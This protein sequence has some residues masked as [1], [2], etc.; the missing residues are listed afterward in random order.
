M[1]EAMRRGRC[2]AVLAGMG[3]LVP[4][5]GAQVAFRDA[6]RRAV[7]N[8]PRV[9]A[10][11][12]DVK[13][14][15][16]GV[17]AVRDM[18][19][20]SVVMGGGVGDAY[21]ITLTVPTIFTVSA[22][23]LVFSLQQRAYIRGA[24]SD[25]EAARLALE[26]VKQQVEE[27]AAI[28]YLS[29]DTAEET[30]AAL[31]EQYEYAEKLAAIMQDRLHAN[32]ESELAVLQYR[33]GELQITLARMDAADQVEDL[34]GHLAQ[35]TGI[36]A[37]G[38]KIAPETIPAISAASV[39]ETVGEGG[40]METPGIRAAAASD[41]AK[42]DRARGDAEYT[43]RPQVSFAATYGRV[44][45][46]ENVSQYYNLNGIYNTASF[47]FTVQFPLLDRVRKA[48]ADESRLDAKLA[49]MDLEVLRSDERAGRHKLSR[50]LPELTTKAELADLNYEIAQKQVESAEAEAQHAT[51]EPPVT[52][53]ET[54]NAHIEERQ[55]YMEVLSAKLEARKA[56]ITYLRM[57]NQL[58]G[59][60]GTLPETAS[61]K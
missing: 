1:R 44:S 2:I 33:R 5:C 51:G 7:E 8:S 28:T 47:G 13:K 38:L 59:W 32:L 50:S 4:A 19:I 10:A 42:A 14:A 25:L 46:I 6:I 20:P 23:S 31:D 45:P 12:S 21:G 36:A 18:Y 16:A 37:D 34:R 58:D 56:Q 17:A 35:L 22:Q 39:P 40:F 41:R 53:K 30:K 29:V 15:Q 26:E 11:E 54:I 9:K 55:K 60:L 3:V 61:G 24:K 52:P 27:D 43:W 57:T 49:E 48:A